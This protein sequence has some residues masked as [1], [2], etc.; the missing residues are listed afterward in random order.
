MADPS[1]DPNPPASDAGLRH[2]LTMQF[3]IA[4]VDGEAGRRL[5]ALQAEVILD[6][7]TWLHEHRSDAT[8]D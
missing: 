2:E 7:L 6:V 3:D 8:S 1:S 5:A 4:V